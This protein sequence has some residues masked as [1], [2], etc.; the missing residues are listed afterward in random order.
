MKVRLI[1][2]ILGSSKQ[3]STLGK[4]LE[5]HARMGMGTLCYCFIFT[6]II[7]LKAIVR[8]S[9]IKQS[10]KGVITAGE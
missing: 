7:A 5:N 3:P 1:I 6:Y 9:S 4:R 8:A 10:S 2:L